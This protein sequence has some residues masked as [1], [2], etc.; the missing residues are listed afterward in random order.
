MANKPDL[1]GQVFGR[2]T[3]IA[4]S[5]KVGAKRQWRCA[6][7]CGR[8]AKATTSDLRYGGVASCG[9]LLKG[10][11]SANFRHGHSARS[12][13][14]PTYNSWRSMHE[15]CSNPKSIRFAQYGGRGIR[16]C[17]RWQSFDAFVTDMGE[18][19]PPLTLDRIDVDG[20]YAPENCRWATPV[21]QRHN[22]RDSH[23]GPRP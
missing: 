5:G 1:A 17:D 18:R 8:E 9:C 10:E 3:V 23:R 15:R 6:C 7:D 22:R 19:T 12:G 2:L 13:P 4:P 16:V 20:D 11:T 14:S 21:E